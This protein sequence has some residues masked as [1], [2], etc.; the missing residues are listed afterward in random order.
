MK[1]LLVFWLSLG[2]YVGWGQNQA[3]P[4]S[5]TVKEQNEGFTLLFDGKSLD[6]W[7][8]R[9]GQ[10]AV[11]R[12]ADGVI[13]NDSSAPGAT[14]L[15]KEDF[16]NFVLQAEFRAHPGINS[17]LILRQA[18]RGPGPAGNAPQTEVAKGSDGQFYEL[19][20][21]DKI[22]ADRP[23]A[24]LTGSIVNVQRAPIE[25]KIVPGQWNSFVVTMDGDHIVVIYNGKKV[26][27]AHDSR[28]AS[29]SIGLQSAHAAD[30]AGAKIEFR[31]LKVK[32]LP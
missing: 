8:V 11:W 26:V 7:D 14:L 3:A 17:A 32:R 18:R 31:N 5:L 12:V 22:L 29:G 30:P 21:R 19:Q 24:F 13:E 1:R 10:E 25:A 27:D 23:G 20:I 4:N 2:L 16:A 9:P 15:T 6:G 28:L